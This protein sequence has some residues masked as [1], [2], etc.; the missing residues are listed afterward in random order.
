MRKQQEAIEILSQLLVEFNQASP[1]LEPILRSCQHVCQILGWND[2][3]Q[4][5]YRELNGYPFEI[6]LPNYRM[7]KGKL[8]WEP[9]KNKP[10]YINWYSEA[11][12]YGKNPED[13]IVEETVLNLRAN[14]EWIT[15]ASNTG[16]TEITTERK[17]SNIHSGKEIQLQRV[18]EFNGQMFTQ[19]LREIKRLAF[20]FISDSYVYLKYTNEIHSIWDERREKIDEVLQPLGFNNHFAEIEN[21]LNSPNPE[22]WRTVAY[23]CRNLLSDLADYLWKDSRK[24]YIYLPGKG[25][26]GKLSVS[27]K[28]FANKISAYLHQRVSSES[29]RKFLQN[30]LERLSDSIRSIIEY[31][32]MAHGHILKSD[33]ESIAIATYFL[34]G[35]ISTKTD[36]Q[37]VIHY[38]NPASLLNNTTDGTLV[39]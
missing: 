10:Y 35:E 23:A 30:E 3:K 19:C 26:D 24:T 12:V 9:D 13:A 6:P 33:A 14:I 5:F 8:I 36:M 27:K 37:P 1:Q 28:E 29:P 39:A 2:Q 22:S 18:R 21:G 34:V 25:A 31:Q 17:I 4:W 7:I 20:D 32:S 11:I 15:R 16:Y 38:I